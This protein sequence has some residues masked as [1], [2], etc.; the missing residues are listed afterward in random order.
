MIDKDL[1]ARIKMQQQQ[2]EL[3][4]KEIN[5]AITPLLNVRMNAISQINTQILKESAS[6]QPTMLMLEEMG[7]SI[8]TWSEKMQASFN[9]PVLEAMA[10]TTELYKNTV[11]AVMA[12]FTE[13]FIESLKKLPTQVREALITF[14]EHGWYFDWEMGFPDIWGWES[15]FKEGRVDEAEKALCNYFE[16]RID[17]IEEGLSNKFKHRKNIISEAFEAHRAGKYTLSIPALFAQTDGICKD[18]FDRCL[19]SSGKKAFSASSV[20]QITNDTLLAAVL[21]PLDEKLPVIKHR[22]LVMHG[23]SQNYG[24]KINSLKVISLIN[25]VACVAEDE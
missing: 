19:F 23:L 25:Y 6:I 5:E 11:A 12:P 9:A 18:I 21:S 10:N 14:G 2:M 8:A 16:S 17:E 7:E 20:E 3:L 1:L 13:S 15:A 4:S 22:N 24:T